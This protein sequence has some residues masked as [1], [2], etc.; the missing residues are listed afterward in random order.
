MGS[1]ENIVKIEE[2]RRK[3]NEGDLQAAQN[4]LD[5][6]ELKKIKNTLDLNLLA[7]V[8]YEN[9]RY[10]AAADLYLKI[11]DKT[12]SRKSLFKLIEVYIRLNNTEEAE[13]YLKQYQ[14]I[15]PRDF[16]NDIFRYKIDKL[17][18]E[19]FE[20]LIEILENLKTTE[21]TEKWA[22]E[23]AKLYYKAGM[24]K[25]CIRECSD[26]ELWFG[27]GT[28]VEKAKIL[29]SYYSGDTDKNKIMEAIKRRAEI[30][31]AHKVG[32]E[33][34]DTSEI[35][36]QEES[37]YDDTD[38]AESSDVLESNQYLHT[39]F[40]IN[41]E[42]EDFVY[43]LR[44][45]V[46]D[47]MTH[48]EDTVT[49]DNSDYEN[50]N[51]N[52][53]AE[54]QKVTS[55][56]TEEPTYYEEEKLSEDLKAFSRE[57]KVVEMEQI[58]VD[59]Y[60]TTLRE[61]GNYEVIDKDQKSD[62]PVEV[63]YDEDDIILQQIATQYQISPEEIFGD[64]LHVESIKKQL[65]KSAN[66]LLQ[67]QSKN[68]MM[69][70]TG[71]EG[72]GKTT[73]AKDMALFF[74]QTGK[75]K[76]SKVAKIKADRLN[77]I[78]IM[79]KKE[80]LEDCC[81]VIENAG[82]LKRGTID[83]LLELIQ[84]MRGDIAVIFEENKQNMNKLFR[85]CPKLIDLLKNRIHLPQYTQEDLMGFANALLKQKEYHLNP[86]AERLLA[87]K[88]NQIEKQS[89]PLRHLEQ[90]CDITQSAMNAADIR[91]AK[92]LTGL[93]VQ[94]GLKDVELLTVLAEDMK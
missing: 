46:Q 38:Y 9:E 21:Y 71:T 10:E 83:G 23:L 55:T 70:I 13:D 69:I 50:Y 85:E 31:Y 68:L 8:Y 90:I 37:A 94:G 14:K 6:M 57:A 48:E 42:N 16:Y 79:S 34:A 5:T 74:F 12:K 75:L 62:I 52:S 58:T 30:I 87:K 36:Q 61:E 19:S 17:K 22:Y 53:S 56:Y 1:Y 54:L 27:D 3:V 67:E 40:M 64:F 88:I 72:S 86:D 33:L 77:T 41:D 11:Y 15:A 93:V 76:S 66:N 51:I 4:V 92:Q 18:G 29:K 80:T 35:M 59:G 7:E 32:E 63:G 28:Y 24:E 82:D 44:K 84:A 2:I 49:D 65:V 91:I 78:N 81:L 45:D 89:E 26:I 73:L 39:D 60:P 20:H 43:G 25:E 47:I